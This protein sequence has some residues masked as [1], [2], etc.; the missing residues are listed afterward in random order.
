M[1]LGDMQEALPLV[2]SYE[3]RESRSMDVLLGTVL[4]DSYC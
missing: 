2:R 1:G 4:Q 3:I